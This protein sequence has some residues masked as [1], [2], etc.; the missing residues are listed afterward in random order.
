MLLELRIQEFAVIESAAIEFGPGLNVLTGETGAG[1]SIIVDALTA[2][3]GARVTADLIRT[4]APA[5]R[6]EARFGVESRGPIGRW[7]EEH[8]LAE[9]GGTRGGDDRCELV[10]AR[11]IMPEGRSRAWINGR[12][13]TV[14]M[15]REL[16]DLLVEVAGQHEGQRLLRPQ[17]HLGLLDAFGGD[18][19]ETQ[20][21]GVGELV[22]LRSELRAEQK[23]LVD[24][25]RDRLRQV[26]MLRYQVDE[27]EAA[28]LQPGEEEELSSRRVRLSNAERLSGAAAAAYAGLYEA[29][30]Q[31]AVDRIGQA[32]GALREAAGLDPALGALAGRIGAIAGELADVAHDLARYSRGIEADPEELVRV[33]ERLDLLRRLRRKYGET[34]EAVLD[35][36][37]EAASALA[38]LDAGDARAS[39]IAATLE[40]LEQD[41][42]GRCARLSELRREAASRLEDGVEQVLRSLEM[43]STR[44]IVGL[45]YDSDPAGLL[46]GDRRVAVGS[47]GADRVEFLLAANPG[48]AP[49]P[50]A[51]IASGGELSRIMLALRHVLAEAGGV[52]VFICD[53]VDAG[54]GSR[55]AGSVAGLLAAVGRKRQ[56]LCVTHLPQ[57]ASLADRHYWV[58]KEMSGGRTRVRVRALGPQERVEEVARMLGGRRPTQIAREHALELLRRGGRS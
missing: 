26:E 4:G 9:E 41:L 34:V 3:L 35:Y 29:D 12:S 10:V 20:C 33:E 23:A 6:A 19:V 36:R 1:K 5:A 21:A 22:R 40:E 44:L 25:E 57:V 32:R 2:A 55:A 47:D 13:A 17:A 45:G 30:G 38:R 52:P 27:I 31:A 28:R 53:E 58:S 42:T 7:L 18:T 50:L 49:R 15:L 16:G 14:G 46:L 54:V 11:E 24:G 37:D 51:R 39:E 43:A 48:E 8:G 56:V